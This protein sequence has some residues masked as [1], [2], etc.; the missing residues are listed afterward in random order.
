MS[1]NGKSRLHYLLLLSCLF[2]LWFY[3]VAS[4]KRLP[5]ANDEVNTIARIRHL[6]LDQPFS[7]AQTLSNLA[8]IS[9]DHGPLYFLLL[10]LWQR[11]AGGDLFVMRLPSVFFA[12]LALAAACRVAR[13]GGGEAAGLA[14]VAL[15]AF[16]SFFLYYAHIARMYTLLA[17]VAGGV[18]WSYWQALQSRSPLKPALWLLL[19]VS[20]AAIM[21]IHYAGLILLAAI[22]LYHVLFANRGGR[23][24]RI[25]ALMLVAAL[26]FSAWLPV[27]LEG[28]NVS[29]VLSEKP[30]SWLEALGAAFAVFSNGIVILP[31]VAAGLLLRYR[32]RLNPAQRYIALVPLFAALILLGFN[33]LTPLLV[34][35]RLRYLA[36]I[37]L[38]V[39]AAFAFALDCLPA[40]KPP[41]IVLACLW[42]AASFAFAGASAFA[43]YTNRRALGEDQLVHYQA[44]QYDLGETHGYDQLI[45]SFHPQASAV[46]KTIEYYRSTLDGWKSIVHLSYDDGGQLRIESRGAAHSTL[47]G[48]A[49]GSD[50]LWAIH[51][52]AQ[53]D[54]RAMDLYGAWLI[55][56]Y[57]PCKRFV[58]QPNNVIEF[59]L[60][61]SL[62]CALPLAEQPLAIRY[63]EGMR[64]DNILVETTADALQV[65]FWWRAI[66]PGEFSY[67]LQVHDAGGRRAL[68]EDA[69]ID[70]A[71]LDAK[72]LD[73]AA[74]PSGEYTL[75]L[76]VYDF[77]TGASQAGELTGTGERFERAVE[78][79][80]FSRG[81]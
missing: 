18:V 1:R 33:Q 3:G 19:F 62:P 74:L 72:R 27:A 6:G 70:R 15:L 9:P 57:R 16:L 61:K 38:P 76:I 8:A 25:S 78:I 41:R 60:K 39:A 68:G 69:I 59:Y 43:V 7:L 30:L 14:A 40:R 36:F 34:E 49:A 42:I 80:R 50:G 29:S 71:P 58:E 54:L 51:N 48:I 4:L 44:F 56:R 12:V 64:L 65:Y 22:G 37:A 77:D 2:Y 32:K 23:W 63:S 67:S 75:Q 21:Y 46:W 53:T 73:I 5:I 13:L 55:E 52:P 79:E 45:L 24:W 31:A 28:M 26:M 17:L 81:A 35:Q 66:E 20:S 11:V 10:N 47:E